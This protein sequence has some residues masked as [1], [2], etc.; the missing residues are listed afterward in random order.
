MTAG[1]R[2]WHRNGPLGSPR[3][4]L[5]RQKYLPLTDTDMWRRACSC[6]N[7]ASFASLGLSLVIFLSWRPLAPFHSINLST[8][9]FCLRS[10]EGSAFGGQPLD[11]SFGDE[12][13][14]GIGWSPNT[15]QRRPQTFS[16]NQVTVQG[17]THSLVFGSGQYHD[18]LQPTPP[19]SYLPV[20]TVESALGRT[21]KCVKHTRMQSELRVT[22]NLQSWMCH[23][24][25][26]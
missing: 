23:N 20:K 25:K 14:W 13:G 15:T 22:F 18:P 1:W 17:I 16:I 21:W 8:R 24:A 6:L 12:W 11:V 9:T 3:V 4:T 26:H 2:W 5:R 7:V 19:H 10:S